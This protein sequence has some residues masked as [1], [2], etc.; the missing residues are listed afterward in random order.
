[1]LFVGTELRLPQTNTL[2]QNVVLERCALHLCNIRGAFALIAV[3]FIFSYAHH[4]VL[5]L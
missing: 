2:G 3:A 1:M 4:L 5:Y